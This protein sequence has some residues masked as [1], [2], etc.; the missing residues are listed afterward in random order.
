M[1]VRRSLIVLTVL[2]VALPLAVFSFRANRSSAS[3][4][5]AGKL[6]YY[7]VQ[8]GNLNDAVTAVGA[9]QAD[10]VA[11]LSF[12][13][14]GRITEI[15]VKPGD[16]VLKGDVLVR[17][18]SAL[19]QI[20][21]DQAREQLDLAQLQKEDATKAP[22]EMDIK[23]AQANLNSAWGAYQSLQNAVKPEDIQAAELKYKQA[24]QNQEDALKERTTARLGYPPEY[25]AQ[26]D[27]K[28]GE[29]SFNTEIARL[30]LESLRS[31]NTAQLNASYARVVQ[32]QKELEKAEVGPTQDVI[33]RATIAVNQA[34][35]GV[36]Q[37]QLALD[38]TSLVAPFDGVVAAVNVEIGA[39]VAPG[40]AVVQLADI[41]PLH[42]TVQVDEVDI[43]RVKEGM[44]AQVRLDALRGVELPAKLDR[45][46]L[47]GSSSNGV[48][49]YDVLVTLNGTDPR[50]RVGMTADASVIVEQ[51]QNVLVVPNI[52]IR[53]DRQ[54]NRAYVNRVG[55][56]GNLQE[57]EITLGLRGQDSSEVTAGLQPGDQI[58]INLGGDQIPG[59]GG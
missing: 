40:L 11:N 2:C 16:T 26:L 4:A 50:V 23:V 25:Y 36:D 45:I 29:A 24:Q 47:V 27:A 7:T 32:A 14:A 22:D 43:R 33:D 44:S 35:A 49:S 46:S 28:V 55:P 18:D 37:A 57:V 1:S 53:L 39:L 41:D 56:D 12:T 8:K 13:K 21:L 9:I 6:Q 54:K 34:Q 3:A 31:R 51:R 52:Y 58:A 15:R 48:I 19:E 42:V 17:Q 20:A 38:K 59:L 5:R 10:A 30:Q